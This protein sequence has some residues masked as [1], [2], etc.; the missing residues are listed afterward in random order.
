MTFDQG[1]YCLLSGLSVRLNIYNT[2]GPKFQEHSPAKIK[3]GF[4]QVANISFSHGGHIGNHVIGEF[5]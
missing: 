4:Q 5:V 1:L 2:R 3:K